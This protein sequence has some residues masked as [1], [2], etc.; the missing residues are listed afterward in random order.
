MIKFFKDESI[1]KKRVL[2]YKTLKNFIP[3]LL[4]YKKNIY[5]YS[6]E[7]GTIFSK[8]SNK[9]I[10]LRLLNHIEKFHKYKKLPK[11]N[12]NYVKNKCNNFYKT[13]TIKRINLFYKRYKVKDNLLPINGSK[14]VKLSLLLNKLNWN[15]LSEGKFGRYHG[16]L[17]FENI[18]YSKNKKFIF[19]DWR[20]EFDKN[21]HYGDIYYDLAKLMH[22]IIVSHDSIIK[23]KYK[24]NWNSNKINYEIKNKK[25]YKSYLKIYTNWLIKKNYSIEKINILTALIF[26]NIA[27]LHHYPYSLFLYA[28]GKKKLIDIVYK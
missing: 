1:S 23:K 26:L 19:L 22:G 16:D 17:H 6:K 3:K 7:N 14:K 13:K 8:I 2:R 9:N 15:F 28:L 12:K 18:I 24:I 5:S 25:I 27:P 20:H 21:V 4:D 10:F 11:F